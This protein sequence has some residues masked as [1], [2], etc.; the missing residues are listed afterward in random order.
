MEHPYPFENIEPCNVFKNKGIWGNL[1]QEPKI[2]SS[3]ILSVYFY[4]ER[5]ARLKSQAY[6]LMRN[7]SR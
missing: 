6:L 2:P 4:V 7:L 3:S 5:A 1:G